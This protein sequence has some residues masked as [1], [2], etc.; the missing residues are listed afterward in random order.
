MKGPMDVYN[1]VMNSLLS[2]K[3]LPSESLINEYKQSKFNRNLNRLPSLDEL[4]KEFG[5][6][7]M[8][9]NTYDKLKKKYR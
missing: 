5:Q 2:L 9:Q 1:L 6:F 4:N 8:S 7:K 3:L